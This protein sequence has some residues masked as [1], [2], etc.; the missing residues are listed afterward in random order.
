MEKYRINKE[1][2]LEFGLY[3]LGDHIPSG[4]TGKR[5]SAQKRLNEIIEASQLAEEAGIDVFGLGESHQTY[6]T[7]QAHTVVLGAIA[8]ATKK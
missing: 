5:I 4:K 6:F 8:Q 3:S 1:N 7:T 2:G